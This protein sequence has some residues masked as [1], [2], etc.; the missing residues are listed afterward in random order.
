MHRTKF[1][2][3]F[4]VTCCALTLA[5]AAS[6]APS[7]DVSTSPSPEVAVPTAPTIR[8]SAVQL[9]DKVVKHLGQTADQL[10]FR[11]VNDSGSAVKYDFSSGQQIDLI[12]NDSAGTEVWNYGKSRTFKPL[13]TH[14]TLKK[15]QALTYIVLWDRRDQGAKP[16][17]AGVYTVTASLKTLPRLVISSTSTIDPDRE[18]G[19][20]TNVGL[21]VNPDSPRANDSIQSGGAQQNDIAPSVSAKTTV[22]VS[23]SS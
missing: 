23:P 15:G 14:H 18:N 4:I 21:A 17:P 8:Y 9:T 12:V 1:N 20:P 2:P 10:T 5:T 22:T 3:Y 16:V 7:P 11:I 6:A 13:I 19:D